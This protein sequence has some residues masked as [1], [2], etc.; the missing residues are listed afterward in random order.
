MNR[1]RLPALVAAGAAALAVAGAS[2]ATA[3]TP[4]KVALRNSESPAAATTPRVGSVA[5]GTQMNFEVELKLADQAGAESFARDVSTPGNASY[6]EFLTP[7]Q[8]EARF[9]PSAADVDQVEQFLTQSGLTVINVSRDRMA[10]EA[11]GT[12]A[13]VEQ[14]FGTSL[15]MHQVDGQSLVL[16]DQNLSVPSNIAG[17]VGGVSGVSDTLEKP[18]KT[19]GAPTTASSPTPASGNQNQPPFPPSP[20]FRVA[21]PCGQ[22]YN[23]IFDTTL[24]QFPGGPANP[25]WVV[26]GY[27]GPQ[28]RSAYG[29][30]D[31][32]TGRGVPWPWSTRT[33]GDCLPARSSSR[34]RTT[35]V[36]PSPPVSSRHRLRPPSTRAAPTRARSWLAGE[37]TLDVEAVHDVAPGATVLAAAA[38]NCDSTAL[39]KAL[40]N[41]IDQHSAQVVSNSTVTTA[42]TCSTPRRS[43]GDRLQPADGG[44]HRRHRDVLQRRQRRRV[45]HHRAGGGGL[46]GLQ[47]LRHRRRR[48]DPPGRAAGQRPASSAGP[49][50]AVSCATTRSCPRAAAPPRRRAW[51]PVDLALDGRSRGGTSVVYPQPFYQQG[52]VPN[53]LSEVNGNTPMRVVPDISMVGDPATGM[54]VGQTQQFPNG[55]FYDQYRI[56]GTSVSSPLLAGVVARADQARGS[57]LGFVNPALYALSGKPSAL[58]DIGPAGNQAQSRSDFANQVDNSDGLLYTTGHRLRGLGAVLHHQG[59]LHHAAGGAA[60]R[61]RLRQHDGARFAGRQLRAGPRRA[62]RETSE[63]PD[64]FVDASGLATPVRWASLL[65]RPPR[66]GAGLRLSELSD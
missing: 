53:S 63:P 17:I 46:P 7:A 39:N 30:N 51:L 28:F 2:V 29:L 9:S 65:G 21:P 43:P 5:S 61:A 52:V 11:S 26:C 36:T 14:A 49:R 15:S 47:P 16:A 3:A 25:P 44:G 34:R 56:G 8:W 31:S 4:A 23:Q 62:L 19:V 35:L 13:Q 27:N 32:N 45:H 66:R 24:P 41:V 48:H 60:H 42:E 38:K 59:R 57:S 20:G 22:Y 37:Q 12:A 10:V 33:C 54:L 50:R 58:L 18:D 64:A 1:L 6:G 40:R 55:V